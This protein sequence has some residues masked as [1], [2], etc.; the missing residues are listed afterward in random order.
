[1]SVHQILT[2]EIRTVF[3]GEKYFLNIILKRVQKPELYMSPSI[4]DILKEADFP[5]DLESQ[6]GVVLQGSA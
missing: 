2:V 3:C 1:M 4:E 5:S 6:V